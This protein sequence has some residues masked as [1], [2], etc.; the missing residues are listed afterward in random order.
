MVV[1]LPMSSRYAE[2]G[3]VGSCGATSLNTLEQRCADEDA[4]GLGDRVDGRQRCVGARPAE[5]R[6]AGPWNNDVLV[7][8]VSP[9]GEVSRIANFERAGV[10]AIARM[11]DGVSFTR[12]ADV[13]IVGD[14]RW[15]G[16]SQT[17]GKVITLLRHGEAGGGRVPCPRTAARP[18]GRV[19]VEVSNDGREFRLVQTSPIPVADPGALPLRE[20]GWMVVGTGPPVRGRPNAGT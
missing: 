3:E 19:W 5:S 10:P 9:L 2:G 7:Y 8:R 11:K 15:R 18:P 4:S 14:R 17:D 13:Q 16:N 12:V 6:T 20:G 1:V